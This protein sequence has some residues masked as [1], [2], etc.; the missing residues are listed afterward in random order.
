MYTVRQID[1]V[2]H[3]HPNVIL[4]GIYKASKKAWKW[5]TLITDDKE[6]ADKFLRDMLYQGS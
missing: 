2:S 1:W 3:H 6:Y 5:Y 4:W